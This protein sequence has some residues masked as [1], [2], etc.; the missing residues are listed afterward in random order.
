MAEDRSGTFAG[1]IAHK[2]NEHPKKFPVA[3][4]LLVGIGGTTAPKP[5]PAF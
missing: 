4:A 5:F 2:S 3:F 1:F